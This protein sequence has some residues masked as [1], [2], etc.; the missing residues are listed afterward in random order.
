MSPLLLHATFA[1]G[2]GL[3]A[4][5]RHLLTR[6]ITHRYPLSTLLVNVAGTFALGVGVAAIGD[7]EGATAEQARRLV[8][9]F[10]GGFTTFSSFAWQSLELRERHTLVHA[11][12]NVLANLVL[13][14][15]AFASGL[16]LGGDAA[17]PL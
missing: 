7:A 4:V 11:A 6:L 9:G 13:C 1:L 3:G 8:F 16:R 10:C 2:G 14:L 5:T 12:L 15:A 17:A